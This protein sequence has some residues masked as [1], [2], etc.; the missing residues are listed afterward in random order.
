MGEVHT[1]CAAPGCG[2]AAKVKGFCRKHYDRIARNGHLNAVENPG[3]F[4]AGQKSTK[5]TCAVDGCDGRHKARGFCEFHASRDARYGSP[6]G[7]PKMRQSRAGRTCSVLACERLPSDAAGFCAM[8]S[9]RNKRYGDPEKS[10]F[11]RGKTGNEKWHPATG[12]YVWRYDPTS[13]H[14]SRNGF[15]YQHRFIIAESIGRCLLTS[16]SV[17]HKNGIRHDNRIENLE[18]W[19]KTQPSGQRVADLVR[20]A[21]EILAL[22]QNLAHSG[23]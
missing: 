1:E 4:K 9:Y 17:H 5:R 8:H 18:L 23:R 13:K 12:G 10:K 2:A 19:S 3:H 14:A 15:V 7:G 11:V 20:W 16:E 22:Y 6:L 21:Q